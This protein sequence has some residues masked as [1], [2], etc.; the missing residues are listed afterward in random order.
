MQL[1][2]LSVTLATYSQRHSSC[3]LLF[4]RIDRECVRVCLCVRVCVFVCLS[5][6][7]VNPVCAV[8]IYIIVC[9]V[10]YYV[11]RYAGCILRQ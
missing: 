1:S 5:T 9:T 3:G 8:Y 11:C 2:V 10:H 6:V 7:N 4:K